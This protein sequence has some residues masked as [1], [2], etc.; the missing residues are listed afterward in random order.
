MPPIYVETDNSNAK[1]KLYDASKAGQA[2]TKAEGKI[3]A[4]VKKILDKDPGFTTIKSNGA[5]GYVVK[6]KLSKLEVENY[7]TKCTLT[8]EIVRYPKAPSNKGKGDEMVSLG[9]HGSATADGT[10]EGSL[11][12]CVEAIAEGM[13]PAGIKAMNTDFLR[14]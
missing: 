14:R 11:V 9:W 2:A 6:L 10:S 8:G 3:Q 1:A 4:V 13:M 5:K 7:K 12:D